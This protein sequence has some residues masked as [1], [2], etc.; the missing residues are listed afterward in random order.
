MVT[1]D[2][3]DHAHEDVVEGDFHVTALEFPEVCGVL[4]RDD[5]R[6]V[7]DHVVFGSG[8]IG[9]IIGVDDFVETNPAA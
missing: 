3:V 4:K 1:F 8:R 6:V 9:V 5:F 2:E 7:R